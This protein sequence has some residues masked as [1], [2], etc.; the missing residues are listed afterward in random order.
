MAQDINAAV[1]SRARGCLLG[2]FAGDSLGGLVEFRDA[3]DIR[4]MYP[5]GVRELADGGSW[6]TIAGQ[7]TD[8]SELALMLARSLVER[9]TFD[10]DAVARAYGHW[11]ASGPFDC[12]GTIAR[13]ASVASRVAANHAATARKFASAESQANGA[14]MRLSPLGV[15]GHA[16]AP[17][18]VAE[19]AR[20]DAR[21]T[22]PHPV[23]QDASAVFAVTIARAVSSGGTASELFDFAMRWADAAGLHADVRADLTAAAEELPADFSRNMGWVRVALHNAFYQLRHAD[24]LEAG[25]V[26]TVMW[27]GDTD[28]NAA[29]AGALLGAVYGESAV[30]RQWREAVLNCRPAVGVA[31]VRRPR[32]REFWPVDA[33]ELADELVRRGAE[34]AKGARRCAP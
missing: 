14:L 6:N 4:A 18:G 16:L 34:Y 28:T 26:D 23:C 11:Y 24:S 1:L 22:H 17:E 12:G 15:F 31:G 25:L 21:L 8:D 33:V 5:A 19:L 27:G 32:P 7:P 9:G 3:E 20:R 2:Q 29:I 30:P 10:D 13:A